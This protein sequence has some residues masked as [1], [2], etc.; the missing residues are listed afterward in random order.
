MNE[1][2]VPDADL[3]TARRA[4]AGRARGRHWGMA[5]QALVGGVWALWAALATAAPSDAAGKPAD[6][7]VDKSRAAAAAPAAPAAAAL[8]PAVEAEIRKNLVE[9]L[10]KLPPIDEVRATPVAGLFEVRYGGSEI[11]YSDLRG[12]TIVTG[13]MIDTRSRVDLTEARIEKLLAIDFERLPFKD[14]I[15]IK[16]GNGSRRMAVFVDPNCGYCKAF[17]RD[18]AGIKDVTVYTFLIPILGPD[19]SAKSRDI[20]CTKDAPAAWRAWM[21]DGQLP[22]K[23]AAACDT[24]AIERNVE[25]ARRQKINGTPAVLFTD[26]T[27]KPGALPAATV[28]KLLATAAAA[29]KKS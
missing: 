8:L 25:F 2:R 15:V 4:V 13:S 29:A 3:P 14:A 24:G 21:I 7:V 20:W 22:N 16:Q 18:L 9:R 28:E 11:L 6:K 1:N 12:D 10:A 5:R 17:E 27:R 19:S 23:A 26:G